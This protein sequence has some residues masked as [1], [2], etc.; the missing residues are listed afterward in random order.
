MK[1]IRSL[2]LTALLLIAAV[3]AYQ[4]WTFIKPHPERNGTAVINVWP[5][6][7]VSDIHKQ[8]SEKGIDMPP[9]NFKIWARTSRAAAKLRRGE[10]V[11]DLKWSDGKILNHVL[12]GLPLFHS[13]TVKE[14]LNIYDIEKIY[15]DAFPKLKAS[16]F[17]AL[18]RNP[19]RLEKM[20][21]PVQKLPTKSRTLEGFLFPETYAYQIYDSAEMLIEAQL[22]QFNRRVMPLLREHPW[23]AEPD[24]IFKLLTLA[25]I[26]EKESGVVAEQPIVASVFWNR[27]KKNMRLESDPTIIYPLLPLF[28]GNIRKTDIQTRNDYNT[29]RM[30]G[31]PRGPIANPGETAI[32]AVLNPATTNYLFF[33]SKGD[34]T[35]VFSEDYATHHKYVKEYI[36]KRRK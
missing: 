35:H 23:A 34:G 17:Q 21:I 29:Y 4:Y 28:D 24:G 31:L 26:V 27:I 16:E 32:R 13:F 25:S 3:V 6:A 9:L 8:L 15:M 1:L 5:G 36:L 33:V 14:G 30:N 12:Y 7:R 10:Y 18:I 20:G 19:K 22:A 2:F 11:V